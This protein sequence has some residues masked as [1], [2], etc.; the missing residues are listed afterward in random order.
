[1]M[2]RLSSGIVML[3]ALA[4]AAP[5]HAQ[6]IRIPARP[7]SMSGEPLSPP[8][9]RLLRPDRG[10]L[11]FSID[12]PLYVALFEMQP[13]RGVR[14][15]YPADDAQPERKLAAGW[16]TVAVPTV[17]VLASEPGTRL[18]QGPLS[19]RV[20]YVVASRRPLGIAPGR[21]SP[22]ALATSMGL[23]DFRSENAGAQARGVIAHYL[24]LRG[25]TYWTSVALTTTKAGL[26]GLPGGV[27]DDRVLCPDGRAYAVARGAP[28]VCPQP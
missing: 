18:G 8:D 2:R 5:A 1:M 16:Q 22:G 3:F 11:R 27:D 14:L 26:A 6:E 28:L 19:P 12:E 4:V 7:L 24:D 17:D 13:G 15:I 20:V 23:G 10:E 25:T 9:V 21:R